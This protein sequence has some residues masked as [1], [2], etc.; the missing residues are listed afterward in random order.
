LDLYGESMELGTNM[1]FWECTGRW[2]QYFHFG[3]VPPNP[4]TGKP[5]FEELDANPPD[6]T[7]HLDVPQH[8][9]E[10]QARKKRIQVRELCL[11]VQKKKKEGDK[12]MVGDE[13]VTTDCSGADEMKESYEWM[14]VRVGGGRPSLSTVQEEGGEGEVTVHSDEL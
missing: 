14:V 6:W 4:L 2:N 9:M 8:M 11:G 5:A 7:V 12:W 3:G 10:D 1:L 13:V